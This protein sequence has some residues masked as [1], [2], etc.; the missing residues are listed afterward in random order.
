MKHIILKIV[1]IVLVLAF[2]IFSGIFYENFGVIRGLR[3]KHLL[4]V[5]PEM[6]EGFKAMG[7]PISNKIAEIEAEYEKDMA[8][9]VEM[10]DNARNDFFDLP[11]ATRDTSE[12]GLDIK[13]IYLDA[14]YKIVILENQKNLEVAT[15]QVERYTK[16]REVRFSE[17]K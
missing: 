5:T 4:K 10:R 7:G 8:E 14:V 11:K 3:A 12:E 6:I 16:G 17:F 15:L 2:V 9:L 1:A 13:Y